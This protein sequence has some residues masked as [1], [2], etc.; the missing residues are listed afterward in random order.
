MQRHEARQPSPAATG[1]DDSITRPQTQ[2]TT[3]VVQLR[4]LRFVQCR[5]SMGIVGTGVLQV[6]GVQ[7]QLIKRVTQIVVVVD[8]LFRAAQRVG[9]R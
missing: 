4:G 6:F 1:L 8:I 9:A 5:I 7:P 2:F 3:Y